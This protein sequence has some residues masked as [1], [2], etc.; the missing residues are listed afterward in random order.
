[1]L[2]LLRQVDPSIL[3]RKHTLM[4]ATLLSCLFYFILFVSFISCPRTVEE[5]ESV[6][7]GGDWPPRVDNAPFLRRKWGKLDHTTGSM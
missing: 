3:L 4:V 2:F 5:V 6:L 1:M 7:A